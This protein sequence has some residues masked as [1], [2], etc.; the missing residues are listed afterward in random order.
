V[1]L[2]S[3]LPRPETL[4]EAWDLL[5]SQA[6][7]IARLHAEN[8]AV[9]AEQVTLRAEVETLRTLVGTLQVQVQAL[10]VRL[11]QTSSNSSRPPSSDPPSRPPRPARP[12]TGR[13]SGGQPGH[14]GHGRGLRPPDEVD[15][16]VVGSPVA[17]AQCGT[18]L[19][20]E[21]ARPE[22]RQ[23]TEL[24][25]V[26]PAVVEYQRHTLTCLACG[27]ATTG[28]WAA[29]LPA[30]AFGPR[31]AATVGYLTGRLGV[32][33]RDAVEALDALFGT[34]V[35]VGS[36]AALEQTVS[37]ALAEP[38]A[39]VQTYVRRQPVLNV[40]EPSWREGPRRG[41]LW[42]GVT[43]LVTVFLVL[44]TR[45]AAGAKQV[46]GE[47]YAGLVGSDRWSAYTW[48]R[49]ERRRVCWAHLI[50]D[51]ESFVAW[52]GESAEVGRALLGQ[53]EQMFQLW[54]RV[55]EGTLS[56]GAFLGA[57]QPIMA[58]V[59]RL[60]RDGTTRGQ[61]KTRGTCRKSL[62]LEVALWTFVHEAGVEPTN[63]AAERPLRRAVLW[64]RRCFGTQ[65]EAGSR[66]VERVLTAVTTLRQQGRDVLDYL[67][68]ACMAA[69]FATTPPSLLPTAETVMPAA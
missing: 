55:R 54:D 31:V 2:F 25:V 9:R 38:V 19:L 40:D 49:P 10:S 33:Q 45:G 67:T 3:R 4:G 60:L 36:I 12:P 35:S 13:S 20:G 24:P 48:L 50:R 32:S 64:R 26:R 63:T 23:V 62:E 1:V 61:P 34:A 21:D 18:L 28:D 68:A 42:I 5:A 17:C 29:G 39:A 11:G 43:Q 27:Q 66:F 69:N 65:S 41:W 51:F 22:R 7:A 47:A 46:L 6:Q 58:E 14:P 59:G 44:A 37:A 15:R 57:M 8:A 53:A 52:G 16:V 56:R 30:G